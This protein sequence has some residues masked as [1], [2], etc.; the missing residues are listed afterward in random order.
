MDALAD[1]LWALALPQ[2]DEDV[3]NRGVQDDDALGEG[4][5]DAAGL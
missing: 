2:F 5:S 3:A 1:G 4:F